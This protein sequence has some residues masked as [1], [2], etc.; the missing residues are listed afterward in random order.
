MYPAVSLFT[1]LLLCLL[2]G[3]YVMRPTQKIVTTMD[4]PAF[5]V[6]QPSPAKNDH[7]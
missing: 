4:M 5:L 2:W 3:G 7:K 6:T 1:V